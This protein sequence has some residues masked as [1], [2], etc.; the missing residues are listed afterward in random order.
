MCNITS[1]VRIEPPVQEADS[2][3]VNASA[4][5]GMIA[6]GVGYSQLEE[7][8][9][10]LNIT[11]IS[12][13]TWDAYHDQVSEAIH[14]TAW[15][16]MTEAAKEEATLAKEFGDVDKEGCPLITVVT[17]G[18]WA[19][20]SYKTKYDSLSGVDTIVDGFVQSMK[21]LGLKYNKLIRDGD[22]SVHRTLF[23]AMP[24]GP[25]MQLKE[26]GIW[27]K[28]LIPVQ[29][30]ASHATGLILDVDENIC[31]NF[32][33]VAAK[34]AGGKRVNFA[35]RYAYQTRCEA[36]VVSINS[37]NKRKGS[38]TQSY[39]A[40]LDYGP[41]AY[42]IE[43]DISEKDYEEKNFLSQLLQEDRRNY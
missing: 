38:A 16:L 26:A 19:K 23:D 39:S 42:R 8:C 15:E 10:A 28:L 2:S 36:D 33:S 4:V 43:E 1:T 13:D 7:I 27:Q 12:R 5:S 20:R 29:R 21:T 30:V 24:C 40:D 22:S 6:T 37:K 41:D 25:D 31:E 11:R 3:N 14:A 9:E 35:L 17:D 18:A 32:N 34:T